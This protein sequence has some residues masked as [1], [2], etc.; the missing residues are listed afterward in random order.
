M[1]KCEPEGVPEFEAEEEFQRVQRGCEEQGEEDDEDDAG[2]DGGATGDEDV[3]EDDAE[4]EED[5][6]RKYMYTDP[7]QSINN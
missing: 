3:Y 4:I 2:D 7:I 1:K 5:R 6:R